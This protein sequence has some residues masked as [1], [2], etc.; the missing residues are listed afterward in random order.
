[1]KPYDLKSLNFFLINGEVMLLT[2]AGL[3]LIMIKISFT[4]AWIFFSKRKVNAKREITFYFATCNMELFYK[5]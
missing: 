5:E 4:A 1:M 3:D 2:E